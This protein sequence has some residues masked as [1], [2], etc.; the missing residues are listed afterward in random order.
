[1]EG[2]ATPNPKRVTDRGGRMNSRGTGSVSGEGLVLL[3][4]GLDRR[5]KEAEEENP[6]PWLA[7]KGVQT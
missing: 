2:M 5:W 3:R 4:M 6:D 1:M 7:G